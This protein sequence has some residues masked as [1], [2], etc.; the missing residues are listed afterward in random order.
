MADVTLSALR[1]ELAQKTAPFT[2]EFPVGDDL[3]EIGFYHLLTIDSKSRAAFYDLLEK[4]GAGR[5]E[6]EAKTSDPF[7]AMTAS[8]R[9][10]MGKLATDRALFRQLAK[11]VGDDFLMWDTIFGGYL[12]HFGVIPGE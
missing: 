5:G 11:I 9:E 8:I 7:A 2:L 3:K 10:V 4:V 12:K 6:E 1:D